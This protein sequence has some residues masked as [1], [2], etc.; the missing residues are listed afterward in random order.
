MAETRTVRCVCLT[1]FPVDEIL[2]SAPIRVGGE[3][4]GFCKPCWEKMTPFEQFVV[5]FA[6]TLPEDGGVNF[7]A[8]FLKALDGKRSLSTPRGIQPTRQQSEGFDKD[9][10]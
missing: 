8:L 2:F 4:Y 10:N 1:E 3:R 7:G 9:P 5:L 6:T